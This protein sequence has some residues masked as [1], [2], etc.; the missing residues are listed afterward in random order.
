MVAG[1]QTGRSAPNATLQMLSK[2]KR[3]KRSSRSRTRPSAAAAAERWAGRRR[4]ATKARRGAGAELVA[5]GLALSRP[6]A[7]GGGEDAGAE[8]VR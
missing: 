4:V 6:E 1:G 2:A 5:G 7:V 8:E 3:R